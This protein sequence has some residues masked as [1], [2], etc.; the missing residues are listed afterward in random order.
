MADSVNDIRAKTSATYEPVPG[1]VVAQVQDAAAAEVMHIT[2][3]S[4]SVSNGVT[5][6]TDSVAASFAAAYDFNTSPSWAARSSSAT[7]VYVAT[8]GIFTVTGF[9]EFASN[10][11]GLR[12]VW[13]R[14]N[15][16]GS[17]DSLAFDARG[18][19][20]GAAMGVTVRA[21]LR[22]SLGDYLELMV[23]QSSGGSLTMSTAWLMMERVSS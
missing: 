9:A 11:T 7:G 19:L 2:A 3:A 6:N 10:A 14:K 21:G 1:I 8:A 18:A 13:L 12:C 17:F 16:A 5:F 22:L 23:F 20:S 4:A 15:G